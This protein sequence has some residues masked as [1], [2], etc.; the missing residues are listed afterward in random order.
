MMSQETLEEKIL[1]VP[2]RGQI[3][4]NIVTD[5]ESTA[6]PRILFLGNS[7]TLHAPKPEIGWY[8]SW[9][10]AASCR[11]KD[12]VHR[13]MTAMRE[14]RPNAAF[15]IAQG[16]IWETTL[17]RCAYETYFADG[18]AFRPDVILSTL[19]AN[20]P[21]NTFEPAVFCRE[22]GRLHR[23]LSRKDGS[24]RLIVAS[25][26]CRSPKKDAAL[27]EYAMKMGARYVEVGD[28]FADPRNLAIG[29]FA[30]EGIQ[31]HPS[32]I[33]MEKL[34]GRYL[35]AIEKSLLEMEDI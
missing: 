5:G 13:I 32:D 17:E 29:L 9:G 12:Y 35:A 24:T 30:H 16:S 25:S 19:E 27:R 8:G 4:E 21:E 3:A 10:M 34:A 20:I 15:C 18:K 22:L 26:M 31:N 14:T 6:W 33:G 11:E 23:Y 2:S 1:K 7:V 28:V